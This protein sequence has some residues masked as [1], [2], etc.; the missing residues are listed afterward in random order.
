MSAAAETQLRSPLTNSAYAVLLAAL[1]VAFAAA[2][3]AAGQSGVGV[4]VTITLPA[5]SPLYCHNAIRRNPGRDPAT[6]VPCRPFL[7]RFAASGT[8]AAP[9]PTPTAPTL[10]MPKPQEITTAGG[11]VV[12]QVASP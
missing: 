4:N 5:V 3:A 12:W 7:D 11:R 2:P 9:A 1:S 8:A 6:L 10:A